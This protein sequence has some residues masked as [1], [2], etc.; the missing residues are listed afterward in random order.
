MRARHPLPSPPRSPAPP[1]LERLEGGE[2]S[3]HHHLTRVRRTGLDRGIAERTRTPILTI[4]SG[5]LC[6]PAYFNHL[7]AQTSQ[8][9]GMMAT[10]SP[11]SLSSRSRCAA[12]L[13]RA[14]Y[15]HRDS[16]HLSP[17][18]GV[19]VRPALS[20]GRRPAAHP[21]RRSPRGPEDHFAI[22]PAG[23]S[24]GHRRVAVS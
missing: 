17:P 15:L 10:L 23:E 22:L 7:W 13:C 8:G 2:E 19:I 16:F 14:P 6:G 12:V 18:E 1:R 9:H 5:Q 4:R 24:P 11:S 20:S 3:C 21:G